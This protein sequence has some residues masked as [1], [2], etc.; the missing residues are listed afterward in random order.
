MQ[1]E[2]DIKEPIKGDIIYVISRNSNWSAKGIE[3]AFIQAGI[4]PQANA[5]K[6]FIRIAI[7]ILGASFTV[8]GTIFFF[9]YNWQYLH[10]FVKL[11]ILEGLVIIPVVIAVALKEKP[12]LKNILLMAASLLV[13]CLFA[14]F[15][16]VY[17]TGA[18]AYD[19]FLGW[20]VFVA[21]WCIAAG[22]MPLWLL[23]LLLVNTTIILYAQQ[24]ASNWPPGLVMSFLF[25][26]NAAAVMI[27]ELMIKRK[28]AMHTWFIRIVTLGAL[29]F[30]TAAISSA[31]FDRTDS[32]LPVNILLAVV[33]YTLAI[34]RSFQTRHVFYLTVVPLSMI[35]IIASLIMRVTG[36]EYILGFLLTA[37]FITV[38]ITLLIRKIL[39]LNKTWHE[40]PLTR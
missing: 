26:I 40:Q 17:Q 38:S 2:T 25:L 34:K 4:Y 12:L 36:D 15:G 22:F 8:A 7:I 39:Q 20:T 31:I 9:A 23:F 19:F 13:G 33:V 5:W 6:K 3:K 10:R 27:A 11:G 1:P 35:I 24:I 28:I 30:S 32:W 16:Q 29:F 14:V 18:N 21:L 37:I